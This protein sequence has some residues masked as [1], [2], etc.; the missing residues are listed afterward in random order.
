MFDLDLDEKISFKY[1]D[2]VPEGYDVSEIQYTF[3]FIDLV[4]KEDVDIEGSIERVAKKY[5]LDKFEFKKYLIDNKYIL[6]KI[7]K[8][9]FSNEIKKYTTKHLKR[10]LKSNGLR[11]SGKRHNL[12][13]RILEIICLEIQ[14][15][16][17]QNQR[18][19]TKTRNEGSGFSMNF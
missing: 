2:N 10:I 5:N 18:Y 13:K 14:S 17:H 11:K 6:T 9:E 8:R 1:A 12:E 15:I 19:F 3:D 16:C 7:D 4:F